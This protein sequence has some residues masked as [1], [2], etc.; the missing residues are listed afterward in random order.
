MHM[1]MYSHMNIFIINIYIENV[2][3]KIKIKK[4]EIGIK[5]QCW[6]DAEQQSGSQT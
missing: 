6:K 3:I 5:S 2:K 4:R 1:D